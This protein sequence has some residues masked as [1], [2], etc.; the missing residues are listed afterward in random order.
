[1]AESLLDHQR[2]HTCN[3]LT[4]SDV[5]KDVVLMGW[6]QSLRDHGGRRFVDLRDRFGITQIVFKP[7]TDEQIHTLAHQ[8]RSEWCIGI[9]GIVE[10]RKINGGA[11]NDRLA[12]G[13]IEVDVKDL[14]IFAKSE[15]LPFMIENNIETHE[16]KRLMHRVL[17]LRRPSLQHNFILRHK[18]VQT[19]RRYFDHNKFLELE[20]PILVKYTP[21]GARN[22]LVPS[23]YMPGNFFA[24]AE[25]PQLF[26]QMFM[27]AGFD[28]YFQIVKCFRDED[29]RGDRQPEFTQI[30][31]EMSFATEEMVYALT[32]GLIKAIFNEALGLVLE[33]P[34]RRMSHEEAMRRYG[35]D[36]PDIRFGMEHHDLTE[37]LHRQDGANVPLFKE[38]LESKGIIKALVVEARHSL[39]R[40]ELEKLEEVVK[41]MGGMGL[42]RAKVGD[43]KTS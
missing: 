20:T 16:D 21:G 12:T 24:L 14:E 33:T 36:K 2:T 23:R 19:I 42:G 22:F 15:A 32:E 3:E 27:M 28:R 11:Y 10:D 9:R 8:L 25:S 39:S 18:I 29:L 38:T 35:S 30:D 31:V 43:N 37:L 6:V 17:D 13:T 7:E 4:I 40:A 1:M 26:K 41:S 5:G 34:F